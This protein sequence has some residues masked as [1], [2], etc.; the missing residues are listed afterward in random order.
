MKARTPLP[1]HACLHVA[2]GNKSEEGNCFTTRIHS[3]SV[4]V[5]IFAIMVV[6]DADKFNALGDTQ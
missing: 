3:S 6:P 5:Q 2:A 4:V 1:H